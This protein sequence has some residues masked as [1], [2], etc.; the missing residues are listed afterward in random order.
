M[1]NF[2]VLYPLCKSLNFHKDTAGSSVHKY[3]E[4]NES[5]EKKEMLHIISSSC[6]VLNKLLGE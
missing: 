2:T 4:R 3:Q 6:I 5:T 1:E